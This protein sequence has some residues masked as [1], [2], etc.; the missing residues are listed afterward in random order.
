MPVEIVVNG[1]VAARRELVADGHVEEFR[2]PLKIDRSSWVAVRILPSAHTNPV[3][4]HVGGRP[5]HD[6]RSAAWCRRAVDVCWAAKHE[7]IRPAE[8]AAAAAAYDEA[9][10][11]YEKLLAAAP[12][13]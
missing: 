9:R 8:R 12:A 4:V 10:A 11:F 2:V 5:I 13:K 3:F 6:G 1:R 7:K